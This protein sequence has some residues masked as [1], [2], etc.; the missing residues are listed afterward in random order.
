MSLQTDTEIDHE[1]EAQVKRTNRRGRIKRS[2][3]KRL[4][5]FSPR[6]KNSEKA[7]AFP[8]AAEG[9][10]AT[11]NL[12]E[13]S[14]INS[15]EDTTISSTH[16]DIQEYNNINQNNNLIACC[17][18]EEEVEEDWYG[19]LSKIID[20]PCSPRNIDTDKPQQEKTPY[21]DD[22]YD[23]DDKM[24]VKIECILKQTIEEEEPIADERMQPILSPQNNTLPHPSDWVQD[25]LLLVAT[26]KSGMSIV[27]IRRV[28]EPSYFDNPHIDEHDEKIDNNQVIQL[29]I[30][31]GKEDESWVIDFQT[32]L[33]AGTALFRIRDAKTWMP[34]TECDNN[35]HANDYFGRYHRRFQMV[36]RGK[37]KS[38]L[39]LGDCVS[40]LLLD[41]PLLTSASP[42]INIDCD[43]ASDEESN[44]IIDT[45]D[46]GRKRASIMKRARTPTNDASLPPKWA[47]RAAVGVASVFNSRIDADLG[48]AN[49]R[50]LSPLCS[51]AQTIS[52]SR[53][54]TIDDGLSVRLDEPHEEPCQDSDASLVYDLLCTSSNKY[55]ATSSNNNVQRRKRY[56]DAVYDA[57]VESIVDNCSNQESADPSPCF[58]PNAEYTFEFLQHLIDYNNLTLDLGK[59]VGH[60]RLGGAIRGQPMRF[61]SAA[62]KQRKSNTELKLEDLDCL[63]SFDLWHKSLIH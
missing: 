17:V 38:N 29:P 19:F 7:V 25:P 39:S 56:C 27:R 42:A 6:S 46:N 23:Y 54:Q 52:V 11:T 28:S 40:G 10:S 8:I 9:A 24:M 37:F 34:S 4:S 14:T 53:Q 20:L 5:P 1:D 55:K 47:L 45:S 41:R 57:R 26:P 3:S 61:I 51:T 44:K 13:E 15:I 32:D 62:A 50:I 30:N 21:I 43:G 2:L 59:L 16:I 35:K 48:C 22:D 18:D 63:W 60:V 12:T 36:I 31:N 49:P 33:F 58:D